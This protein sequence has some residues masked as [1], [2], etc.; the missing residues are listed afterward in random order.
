MSSIYYH[1]SESVFLTERRNK[2]VKTNQKQKSEKVDVIP[3]DGC[4][5]RPLGTIFCDSAHLSL[6]AM[7]EDNM[8]NGFMCG[9][10]KSLPWIGRKEREPRHPQSYF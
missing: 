5:L 1:I 3:K 7:R 4:A 9:N 6:I 10:M 2:K 8:S